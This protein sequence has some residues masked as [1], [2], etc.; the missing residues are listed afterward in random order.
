MWEHPD[1]H[2]RTILVGEKVS[3]HPPVSAFYAINRKKGYVM[4]GSILFK[5]TFT[6]IVFTLLLFFF[7]FDSLR[8][9]QN[10]TINT[11]ERL[12]VLF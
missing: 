9:T 8:L 7:V 5:S 2:S 10:V 11:R 6:V 3:H 4:N 12:L 1:D